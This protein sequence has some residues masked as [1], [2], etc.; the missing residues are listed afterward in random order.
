[1]GARI[2]SL[3][4]TQG[5]GDLFRMHAAAQRDR[6]EFNL[7]F[8]PSTFDVPH[9]AEFDNEYMRALYDVG[10]EPAT[11]GFPWM[12]TPPNFEGP[13]VAAAPVKE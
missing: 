7:A 3:I 4:H 5:V 11:Q 13:S 6:V 1:M 12:K 10:Y 2:P 9:V 8:I